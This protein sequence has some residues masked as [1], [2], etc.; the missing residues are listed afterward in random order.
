MQ[1]YF[2][3]SMLQVTF[4]VFKFESKVKLHKICSVLQTKHHKKLLNFKHQVTCTTSLYLG[5]S[6][7]L[8]YCLVSQTFQ[9]TFLRVLIYLYIK[10]D[11]KFHHFNLEYSNERLFFSANRFLRGQDLAGVLPP[12]LSKLPYIKTMQQEFPSLCSIYYNLLNFLLQ[13]DEPIYWLHRSHS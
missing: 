7:C 10:F 6:F 8:I 3:M 13:N 5:K 2:T 4:S 12:S 1:L 9:E 11:I